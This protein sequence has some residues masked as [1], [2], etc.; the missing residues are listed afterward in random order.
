MIHLHIY[1]IVVLLE[2]LCQSVILNISNNLN[3]NQ[4]LLFILSIS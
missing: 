4:Y 2:R 1:I 3:S